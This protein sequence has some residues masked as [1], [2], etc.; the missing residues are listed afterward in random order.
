MSPDD[1]DPALDPA[2]DNVS[3]RS[4]LEKMS[5]RSVLEAFIG[6]EPGVAPSKAPAW[7][8]DDRLAY[9]EISF[10]SAGRRI[11][12]FV[13]R[14]RTYGKRGGGIVVHEIFGLNDH[15]RDV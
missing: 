7:G 13:C 14:P 15:I 5:W 1:L 9:E 4:F 12:G 3:R 6:A 10:E 2:L 11:D 8:S